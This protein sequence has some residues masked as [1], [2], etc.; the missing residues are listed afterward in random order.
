M[1]FHNKQLSQFLKLALPSVLADQGIPTAD[2][3][4][5]VHRLDLRV[6]KTVGRFLLLAA[7][8]FLTARLGLRLAPPELAISLIWLPTGIATAGLFRWGLRYWPAV[9]LAAWILQ[10]F[11]F[12]IEGPL[13]AAI[14]A[15]QTLAPL[16]AAALLRFFRFHPTFDRRRDI[17]LFSV[18]AA[19]GMMASATGGV[20]GLSLAGLSPWPAF[21]QAWLTWWLG[22]F[23]GVLIA[24]PLLVSITW[25]SWRYILD[26]GGEFLAW[27]LVAGAMFAIIFFTPAQSGVGTLSLVFLPLALTAWAALRFGVS[28]TSFAA[29]SLALI[30][31]AGTAT[32]RGPFLKPELYSGVFLLWSYLGSVTVLSF[33]IMGIEIGREEARR[34]LLNSKSDLEEMNRRLKESIASTKRLAREAAQANAAKSDFLARMSH[35]IR[36]PMNG[37]IGMTDLLLQS[38]LTPEQ[39]DYVDVARLSGES[40]L[41][42]INEI[43]DLSKIEAG[44]LDLEV[45][46]FSPAALVAEVTQ[47]LLPQAEKKGLT[48][49]S[50]IPPGLPAHLRG[51]PGRLRQILVNLADNAIKFTEQGAVTITVAAESADS[52]GTLLRFEIT[53]T[54]VGIPPDRLDHLFQPFVQNDSSTTRKYGGSGLGLAISRQLVELMGGRIGVESR[55]NH[56]TT[57][58]F[59]VRLAAGSQQTSAPSEP[60]ASPT[61]RPLRIL[62][63]EDNPTNQK[64]ARLLLQRLGHAVA[65]VPGGREA[66]AH[67]AQTACDLILM[68]CQMPGMDGYATT[69]AIRSPGSGV[70]NPQIPIL[71]LTANAMTGEAEKC[72]AAGMNGFLTKPIRASELAAALDGVA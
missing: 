62:L 52:R 38:P 54:G 20:T 37:V 46:D 31:A 67:L 10:K 36:T 55:E 2:H 32:G 44:K 71:A 58:W 69:R 27:S 43:L 16:L 33:M 66:L 59:T 12:G 5:S 51:D 14:I 21:G 63:V 9:T 72:R 70:L 3:D 53:D 56:G 22:D 25:Q 4:S 45:L 50:T 6:G 24:A 60:A 1:W 42:L 30:A 13:S 35:E 57:F 49:F 15:G 23:M 39:R 34:A 40:L 41:R 28:G 48:F 11:S 68:D 19:L 61:K 17:G 7:G 8:Y 29:L 65:V 18:A 47:S 26:R 64:V